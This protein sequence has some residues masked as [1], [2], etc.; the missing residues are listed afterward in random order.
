MLNRLFFTIYINFLTGVDKF[1]SKRPSDT[2]NWM[3]DR[4]T[5]RNIAFYSLLSTWHL[6]PVFLMCKS[7]RNEAF[8]V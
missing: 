2:K 1:L 4:D 5:I 6:Q 3:F 8:V 7:F